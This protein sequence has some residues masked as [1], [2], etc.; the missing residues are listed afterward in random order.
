MLKNYLK[1]TL[2][3]LRRSK[4]YAVINILGLAVGMA[5]CLLIARYLQHEQSYDQHHA[6][7]DR[8]V[9][10]A[11][12][13]T[14]GEQNVQSAM[15]AI[16]LA[17]AMAEEIPEVAQATRLW[18]DRAGAMTVYADDAQFLEN[19]VVFADPNVFDVFTFPLQDGDPATALAEPYTVVLTESMAQKYF[20]DANPVGQTLNFR[21]PSD[22]DVFTYTVTG[23]MADLPATSH[24]KIDFLASYVTQRWSEAQAWMGFG[25]YT[26]ALLQEGTS[27]RVVENKLA[28]VIERHAGPQVMERFGISYDAFLATGQGYR[29]FTQPITD[30]HLKSSL[31]D[32]FGPNGSQTYVWV[33]SLVAVFILL[34]ACI[35][36]MNLATA[37]SA[38]RAKEVGVRKVLGAVRSRLVAQFL[39]ESVLLSVLALVVAGALISVALPLF[40]A[41]TGLSLTLD[42]G[43]VPLITTLVVLGLG[44]GLLAGCYPAFYLS[45]FRPAL[46]LKQTTRTGPGASL[47][48]N[49]LVVFQFA[50][51]IVLIAGTV[52]V[53][54][55][56]GF[57][58]A[59]NLG[60]DTEEVVVLEGAE[61]MGPQ[62]EAF[63]G[64]L[65]DLPGIERVTNSELVPGRPFSGSLFRME[66]APEDEVTALDFTYASF[67]FVETLGLELV[68]GR[69][70]DRNRPADSLAVI[71][72]EAAIAKL[73]LTDPIGKNLVWGGESTY[74]IVGV[75]RDFHIASLHHPI[76]GVALLGPDPRNTN[77]PNLLVSARV[78]TDNLPQT[79]AEIEATW[80]EFA[81]EQPFVYTFLDQ[82]FAAMYQS[83]QATGRLVAVFAFLALLIACIGL[84]GLAAFTAER[85]TKEIGVRKV[86]G[87]TVPQLVGL[88]SQDFV[89]LVAVGFVVAVPVIYFAMQ[90]WLQAFAY[91]MELGVAPFLLG[92]LLT[93]AIALVTV[94]YQSIKAALRDPVKSL[95][96]E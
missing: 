81:P 69:S 11:L 27:A 72:N 22:R 82:D 68:A 44:V 70:L 51:S 33:F 89:K 13:A 73:G 94:S 40:N 96:Y 15:S 57:L 83:E 5:C 67:D 49:V 14:L 23:V 74:T 50:I 36:F 6:N 66:G 24:L 61:M 86:L 53:Y 65:R 55:Q 71:L 18:H 25:V 17:R 2:R 12:D 38:E 9:R 47:F 80:Q 30:I 77:R 59:K 37:R 92:G 7:A 29:Y 10:V 1:I 52:V 43:A 91:R 85:R 4:G 19:N 87:A 32:E 39:A 41:L 60:F 8:V 78:E 42:T 84:F 58:Q 26:Y 46:V 31:E 88:L 45:R 64:A 79:L 90:Q 16:P 93:L 34:I 3:N 63:R 56:M 75:V 76:T 21:E 95:R 28:Q 48:R 20:G 62:A 35:N 54:Q